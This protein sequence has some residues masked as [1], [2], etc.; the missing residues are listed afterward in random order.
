MASSARSSAASSAELTLV[1]AELRTIDAETAGRHYAEHE[2]KPFYG[3]LVEFIGRSPR[4]GVRA[5]GPGG[6]EAV[7]R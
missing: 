4:P 5:R 2:G 6:T 3:E 7:A 1:A